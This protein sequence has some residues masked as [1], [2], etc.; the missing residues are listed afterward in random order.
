MFRVSSVQRHRLEQSEHGRFVNGARTYLRKRYTRR[1]AAM[2]DP[3]LDAW[4]AAG[5]AHAA[6]FRITREIDVLQFLGIRLTLGDGFDGNPASAWAVD[7]LSTDCPA[8][9]RLE[10][11]VERLAFDESCKPVPPNE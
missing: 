9:E 11:V 2:D 7:I 10:L 3:V 5:I 8:P 1:A 6:K 4:I